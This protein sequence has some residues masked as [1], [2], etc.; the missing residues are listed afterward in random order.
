[1][2]RAYIV[3]VLALLLAGCAV[4]SQKN[5]IRDARLALA[6]VGEATKAADLAAKEHFE[7]FP[8]SDTENYC[9]GEIATLVLEEIVSALHGAADSVKLW[10]VSLAV[11]LARKDAGESTTIEWGSVLSSEAEWFKLAVEVISVLDFAMREIEHAGV[12]LPVVVKY[13]WGFL[14]GLTGKAERPPYEMT[15]GDLGV[16]AEY[17]GGGS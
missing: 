10:E 7:Q 14:Y 15:W 9:K 2:R 17:V 1:M 11:Y 4:N 6:I 8:A 12:K 5:G 3:P 13:A 16:C